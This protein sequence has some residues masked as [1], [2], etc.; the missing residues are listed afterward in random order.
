M[1]AIKKIDIHAHATPY[2][3][4]APKNVE[5]GYRQVCAEEVI[6]FYDKLNI[7]RGILL[8]LCSPEYIFEIV[9][10]ESCKAISDKYPDR[11]S[12]FCGIDPRMAQNR[13]DSDLGM[14]MEHYKSLG[15]LGIGELTAN[16]YADDVRMDNLFYHAARCSMPVT[17]HIAPRIG[18]FYGIVDDLGL[19]R[20]ESMLKKH[21]DLKLIGHSQLFWAEMSSDVN[22]Q[23]RTGYPTGRVTEGRIAKLLREYEG[24]YCDLSAGSGANSLMRD[25]DYAV[26]FIEEFSDRLLYG[27]DICTVTNTHPYRFD[28]FL[29]ELL[30]QGGISKENYYKLV[31]GN[32]EKLLGFNR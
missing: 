30:E 31:R 6:A 12:W 14:L 1:K 22:E 28:A 24:L 9:T 16:M 25:P 11:F 27:C 26:R 32:A 17:I 21:K 18:D 4:Y 8:P 20:I 7:E 13:T 19:P 3:S 10:S 15:A 2:P 23:N 5:T 29:T